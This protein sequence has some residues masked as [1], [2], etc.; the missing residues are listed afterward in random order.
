MVPALVKKKVIP[1]AVNKGTDAQH[2]TLPSA[3]QPRPAENITHQIRQRQIAH[4][5]LSSLPVHD[6]SDGA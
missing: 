3:S 2:G 1:R 5:R 6:E 4:Q